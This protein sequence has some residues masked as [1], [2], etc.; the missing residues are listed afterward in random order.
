MTLCRNCGMGNSRDAI[1]CANC[2]AP[3][4]KERPHQICP[5]CKMEITSSESLYCM[6]CG[7]KLPDFN[8]R[9][10][11]TR[12]KIS[13]ANIVTTG[14]DFLR[15]RPETLKIV[16]IM[17]PIM[18]IF[19]ILIDL[20]LGGLSM[21]TPVLNDNYY[22]LDSI[23]DLLFAEI[24][25]VLVLLIL[26]LTVSFILTTFFSA[27]VLSSFKQ[28]LELP[29]E[30]KIDLQKSFRKAIG[31]FIQILGARLLAFGIFFGILFLVLVVPISVVLLLNSPSAIGIVALLLLLDIVFIIAIVILFTVLSSYIEPII[32][33]GD[34]GVIASI[35][36]AYKFGRRYL[37]STLGALIIF[38][39]L[40]GIASLFLS[41]FQWWTTIITTPITLTIN[42]MQYCGLAWAYA[43]FSQ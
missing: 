25:R 31:Y 11:S 33:I 8:T 41:S 1:Y 23:F 30:R 2:G 6:N 38:V 12:D 26:Q 3:L 24:I 32:V 10:V 37:W 34:T 36:K 5:N 39:V 20:G 4:I 14:V 42:I 29:E 27:W 7:A 17:A 22:S 21:R 28:S 43:H 18:I 13:A 9:T 19:N 35:S 40:Q 15:D 16:L